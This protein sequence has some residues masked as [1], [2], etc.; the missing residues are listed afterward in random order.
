MDYN[1]QELLKELQ[2][3]IRIRDGK[4]KRMAFLEES[5]PSVRE[6]RKHQKDVDSLQE[7]IE[8]TKCKIQNQCHHVWYQIGFC[9]D[10]LLDCNVWNLR[11]I[12]CGR[13]LEIT[14]NEHLDEKPYYPHIIYED[15]EAGLSFDEAKKKYIEFEKKEGT[16]KAAELVLSLSQKPKGLQ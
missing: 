15:N 16:K 10:D 7:K 13:T 6:Y 8:N 3:F 1:S 5:D 14:Q 12:A 11:C 4:K 2:E 9:R